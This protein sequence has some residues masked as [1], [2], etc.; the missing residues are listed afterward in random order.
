MDLLKLVGSISLDASGYYKAL[1]KADA[2]AVSFA[3]S[4]N[5]KTDSVRKG[6]AKVGKIVAGSVVA[7]VGLLTKKAVSSYA[8][9]EQLVGGVET[10]FG[11]GGKSLEKYAEQTGQTVEQAKGKYNDL[12]TAQKTVL[13]NANKAYMTAGLS[14]NQYMETV[15]SF[16]GSLIQSLGGDTKKAA[17]YADMAIQDMSDNSNKMGTAMERIQY[18]YQGFSKQN[19]TMLDNLN[20]GYG[21]TKT[22]MMRLLDDAEKLPAAIGKKFDISNYSDVIEAIHLVQDQMRIT[23]TTAEEA[24]HTIEGSFKMMKASWEN[25]LTAMGNEGDMTQYIDTFVNSVEILGENL[26]PVVERI[27]ER[28]GT[29]IIESINGIGTRLAEEQLPVLAPILNNLGN[30]LVTVTLGFI[31]LSVAMNIGSTIAS[32]GKGFLSLFGILKNNSIFVIIALIA[33]LV[34]YLVNLWKTNEDFRN[35]VIGLWEEFKG[36]IKGIVDGVIKVW[37]GIKEGFSQIVDAVKGVAKSAW[38]GITNLIINPIKKVVSKVKT[39]WTNI[40]T[41]FSNA[42]TSIKTSVSNKFN[43]IKNTISNIITNI[44]TIAKAKFKAVKEA[45]TQPIENA[46][47]KIL[48]IIEKIKNAFANMKIKFP[49]FHLPKFSVKTKKKNLK[50]GG[51]A[52]VPEIVQ[53]AKAMNKPYM[54]TGGLTLFGAG[55]MG[56]EIL[57]GK[58]SLMN[59]ITEAMSGAKTESVDTGNNVQITNYITV[60]GAESPEAFVKEFVKKL[61]LEMRTV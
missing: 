60:D 20:L 7:G 42:I 43:A 29:M 14:Q 9:Y 28:L 37:D 17:E 15:T 48:D 35:K 46:K 31:A 44:K 45:V 3:K 18:A 49:K 22:E 6:F 5:D 54:F 50:G 41:T 30:V 10:L 40:K 36:R 34:L 53:N 52:D 19:Y 26:Y 8:Q 13:D 58:A 12:M 24:T 25:L 11:A 61:K 21:G 38:N 4:V 27:I 51:S 59:D 1:D 39:V 33:T 32:V 55:E 16:S 57:Y 2:R 47:K 56:D 23:N